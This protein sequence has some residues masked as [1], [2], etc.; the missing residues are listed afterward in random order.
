[1][2]YKV[3]FYLVHVTHMI[4]MYCIPHITCTGSCCYAV[5]CDMWNQ[6]GSHKRWPGG[7]IYY[8]C[9]PCTISF[10]QSIATHL[11]IS[12]D[13]KVHGANMGPT[14]VLSAPGGPHVGFMNLAIWEGLVYSPD[15][16]MHD[17]VLDKVERVPEK[18]QWWHQ[19]TCPCLKTFHW[20]HIDTSSSRDLLT[21]AYEVTIQRLR[22]PH[23]KLKVSKIL[24]LW[25]MGS[26]FCVK[27]QRCSLKPNTEFWTHTPQNMHFTMC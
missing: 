22:K 9:F 18:H 7:I 2:L 23:T 16:Q 19:V 14:W 6:R 10:S 24:I 20:D 15:I 11:K 17:N 1:M 8:Y 4:S 12:P 26:I 21:R 25:Y 5:S 3:Y 27:C 13:S